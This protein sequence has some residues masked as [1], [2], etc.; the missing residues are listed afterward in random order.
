MKPVR[1]RRNSNCVICGTRL[2]VKT[3]E[4]DIQWHPSLVDDKGIYCD[5]CYAKLEADR[6]KRDIGPRQE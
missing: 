3:A 4:G 2:S 6:A 1:N 5:A